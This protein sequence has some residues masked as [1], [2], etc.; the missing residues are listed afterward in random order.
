M[1]RRRAKGWRGRTRYAHPKREVFGFKS[2]N[3][4][5]YWSVTEDGDR[6]IVREQTAGGSTKRHRKVK[7][8]AKALQIV[9]KWVG[10]KEPELKMAANKRRAMRRGRK[11]TRR[12]R[13]RRTTR[14]TRRVTRRRGRRTTRRR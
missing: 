9:W 7:S 6:Y 13:H 14:R 12:A 8:E 11:T 3:T 5:T 4:G 10:A 2:P 1:K